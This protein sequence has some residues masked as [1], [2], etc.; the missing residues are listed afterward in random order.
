MKPIATLDLE[1]DPFKHGRLPKAFACGFFDGN[2]YQSIWSK[3]EHIVLG[4]AL[5]RASTFPGIVYAHNGGRFDFLGFL[6]KVA[7]TKLHGQRPDII[8]NRIARMRFGEGEIRDSWSILP[9]PLKS[10]DKGNI[11]IR[12]FERNRRERHKREIMDYLNRDCVS[13]YKLVEAFLYRHGQRPLTAASAGMAHAKELGYNW[14]NFNESDDT[15]FRQWY[16][17]GHVECW[18][19]GIHRGRFSLFDIKSAYP[20]AMVHPH[21]VGREFSLITRPKRILG[22]DF[23][24]IQGISHG[25]FPI[26]GDEREGLSYPRIEGRFRV[27][28]WEY[29]AAR[30]CSLFR[31]SVVCVERPS[32]TSDFSLY[33]NHWYAEKE[34]AEREGDAAGRLIAKIMLNALYGK[35]AQDP[36]HFDDWII[37]SA[38][39]DTRRIDELIYHGF[40]E[41]YVDEPNGYAF[42]CRASTKA[43]RYYNVAT[44]AS[45]TG[46]VR[47][48]LLR[49]RHDTGALYGDT[50]S[51][52]CPRNQHPSGRADRLGGWSLEVEAD[53]LY[54]ARKKLYAARL[55][56]QYCKDAAQAK[57][58]G[59][60]WDTDSKRGWKIASK[61]C[62][63][64]P[65]E[66]LQVC[67]GKTVTYR[68]AAPC[69]SLNRVTDFVTRRIKMAS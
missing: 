28:G 11:D 34:R 18:K 61:G 31:G 15:K 66:M 30:D 23:L 20:Y 3:R 32:H 16:F 52:W 36:S 14:E 48:M 43:K 8:G 51:V 67:S 53:L 24:V 33:V 19:P 29:L 22:S 35:Y 56:P 55:L 40:E 2:Q 65:Q 37:E 38:E 1:T 47:A 12:K 27:T 25:A 57:K 17:G 45:I 13:L 10:Y 39:P 62:R 58:K 49:A 50:D 64:T 44:A 41:G 42:W 63:L 7:G 59:Y 60:Y 9:A 54:L 4:W 5:Q 69:Y 26:R 46:F 21:P 68:S 6:F